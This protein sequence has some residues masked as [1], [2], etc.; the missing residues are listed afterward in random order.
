[1]KFKDMLLSIANV[2][3]KPIDTIG[4]DIE[5][6]LYT[7]SSTGKPT[8]L[9]LLLGWTIA[10]TAAPL[11][12]LFVTTVAVSA[13]L[14]ALGVALSAVFDPFII[15]GLVAFT[16]VKKAIEHGDAVDTKHVMGLVGIAV[17][18]GIPA[19]FA[20]HSTVYNW[21]LA[22]CKSWLVYLL[23]QGIVLVNWL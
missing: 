18:A 23:T 12:S 15:I 14:L 5:Y 19:V 6:W 2:R 17:L 13:T 3:N 1:M 9:W 4:T 16:N 20:A 8:W 10:F 22:S 7:K 21:S 11:I